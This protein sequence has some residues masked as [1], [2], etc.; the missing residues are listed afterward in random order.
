M[1]VTN[2]KEGIHKGYSMD[3]SE[4]KK[5]N[6]QTSEIR[7]MEVLDNLC[8]RMRLYQARAGPEFPYIR[9]AVG[10][11]REVFNDMSKKSKVKLNFELP[12]DI[13]DDY[14]HEI[15]RV[16]FECIHLLEKVEEHLEDWYF[17]HQNEDLMKWL[18]EG[19]I[20]T[21]QERGTT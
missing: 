9:G 4:D 21:Q 10:H 15:T 12:D 5:I 17:N 2:N 18:C 14:T 11:L 13:I 16:K 1:K 19:K 20:L 6:Y 7:F 3:L 8:D